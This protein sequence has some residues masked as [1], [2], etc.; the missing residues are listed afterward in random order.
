METLCIVI[1]IHLSTVDQKFMN[2]LFFFFLVSIH[3]KLIVCFSIVLCFFPVCV[4][5]EDHPFTDNVTTI[6]PWIQITV[7]YVFK[8]L[9]IFFWKLCFRTSYVLA[10]L[11]WEL[12]RVNVFSWP[13][14]TNQTV[15]WLSS[16]SYSFGLESFLV[17]SWGFLYCA[18]FFVCLKHSFNESSIS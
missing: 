3:L 11:R 15:W 13:L 6:G 16:R 1:Y 10:L 12:V 17:D 8:G 7:N 2:S 18:C 14:I 5:L 9:K 4:C